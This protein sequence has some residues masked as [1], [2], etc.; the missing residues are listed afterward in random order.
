LGGI[1]IAGQRGAFAL[2]AAIVFG[3]AATLIWIVV[4]MFS[5]QYFSFLGV[6]LAAMAVTAAAIAALGLRKK[7]V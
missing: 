5:S 1:L 4:T 7:R 2:V 6:T 3:A